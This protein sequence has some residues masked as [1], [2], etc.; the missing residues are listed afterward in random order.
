MGHDN[1]HMYTQIKTCP[2]CNKNFTASVS[3]WAYAIRSGTHRPKFF[4]SWSCLQKYRKEK[5]QYDERRI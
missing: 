5:P 2:V 1:V 4:C 3:E